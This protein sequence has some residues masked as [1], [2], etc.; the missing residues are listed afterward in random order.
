MNNW[1]TPIIRYFHPLLQLLVWWTKKARSSL[2]FISKGKCGIIIYCIVRQEEALNIKCRAR[3]THHLSHSQRNAMSKF[4]INEL[5]FSNSP[6]LESVL[7]QPQRTYFCFFRVV[8]SDS[9]EALR[10]SRRT[11]IRREPMLSKSCLLRC[12]RPSFS[13]R[14]PLLTFF[15]DFGLSLRRLRQLQN[16][17]S[18]T[19]S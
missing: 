9:L 13:P 12:S 18:L 11:A 7:H 2:F 3:R 1:I 16:S 4:E 6:S 15:T 8:D 5:N 19:C 17:F 14:T 10:L